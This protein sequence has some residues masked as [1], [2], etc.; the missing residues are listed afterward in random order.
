MLQLPCFK[1]Q[2][3]RLRFEHLTNELGLS[4]N[5]VWSIIQDSKGYM[6]FGTLDGLNKY[7]GYTITTFQFRPHDTTSIS[8]NI[9]YTLYEDAEGMIW[10]GTTEGGICK[11]NPFTQVFTTY[12][13][14]QSKNQF[15]PPL[16]AVSAIM[17]WEP[18]RFA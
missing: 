10:I 14:P 17:G 4:G 18:K 5:N 12:K 13:P 1:G 16:R 8:Q 2:A 6:W 3:Q 9:I 7:D 11:F 15:I